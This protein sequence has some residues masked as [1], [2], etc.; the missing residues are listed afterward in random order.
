MWCKAITASTAFCQLRSSVFELRTLNHVLLITLPVC[1]PSRT[2]PIRKDEMAPA[3]AAVEF[4]PGPLGLGEPVGDGVDDGRMMAEAAVAA[5]DLDVLGLEPVLVQA[6]L[7]GA[8][9]VR[10]AVDGGG[11]H[12]R[13][14]SQRIEHGL[15][16][17][18]AAAHD[19]IGAPGIGRFGRARERTTQA[20][21]ASHPV[22]HD[23]CELACIEA[24]QAAGDGG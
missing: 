2:L 18:P 13:R 6:G 19:L 5:I 10:S 16:F 22:G 1:E 14:R 17:D 12:R 9:A 21:Q 7:P 23:L 24:G 3:S 11:W 20:D 15:V 8:D 4:L